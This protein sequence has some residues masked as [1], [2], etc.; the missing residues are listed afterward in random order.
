MNRV[1]YDSDHGRMTCPACQRPIS[2]CKCEQATPVADDGIVRIR[3]EVRRGKPTTVVIGVPLAEPDL[4]V[5]AKALKKKCSSGG[6]AKDGQIE[7]QGDHRDLM[8]R[9]LAA[10]GYT[11]KLAGG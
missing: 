2:R 10:R 1:V 6:S 5:L 3:R 8:V 4:R 11:V 7:L 9:E